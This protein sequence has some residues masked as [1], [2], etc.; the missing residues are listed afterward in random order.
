MIFWFRW[1]IQL[2]RNHK[3]NF[4][5]KPECK[6][7]TARRKPL[8]SSKMNLNY[9]MLNTITNIYTE[10]DWSGI[11]RF[12]LFIHHRHQKSTDRSVQCFTQVNIQWTFWKMIVHGSL[13]MNN[14]FILRRTWPV[15]QAILIETDCLFG[16]HQVGLHRYW[17]Q[18][19][20]FSKSYY[21]QVR[22]RKNSAVWDLR[23]G[24]WRPVSNVLGSKAYTH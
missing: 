10:T 8:S 12:I 3:I 6:T 24:P 13:I 23:A 2:E 1:N 19:K 5:I 14:C 21:D 18:S 11:N 4:K 7:N 9:F 17:I 20:R 16:N 22:V 15:R